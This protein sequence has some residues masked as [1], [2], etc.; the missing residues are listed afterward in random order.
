MVSRLRRLT[1]AAGLSALAAV[2]AT[3]LAQAAEGST[4]VIGVSV[5][6]PHPPG[7]VGQRPRVIVHAYDVD[8]APT[9]AAE[10]EAAAESIYQSDDRLSLVPFFDLLNDPPRKIADQL[11]AAEAALKAGTAAF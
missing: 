11:H 1:L 5:P 10:L 3:R 7:R 9:M 4:P 2:A 6:L 8:G